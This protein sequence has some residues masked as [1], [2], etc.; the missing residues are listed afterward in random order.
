MRFLS[1]GRFLCIDLA[2]LLESSR[3]LDESSHQHAFGAA[4][5]LSVVVADIHRRLDRTSLA[6]G[7]TTAL[8]IALHFAIVPSDLADDIVESFIDIDS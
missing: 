2:R 6:V 5:R 1:P 4:P 8:R 3:V 7:H